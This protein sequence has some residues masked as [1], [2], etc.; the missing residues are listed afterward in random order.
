VRVRRYR[1]S[2]EAAVL[3]LHV[4]A[5]EHAG[6]Y[7]PGPWNDDLRAI[8]EL[9]D[10]FLVGHAD[11]QLVAMGGLRRLSATVGEVKRMRVHPDRQREGLG[12]A[13]LDRLEAS[14]AA[15]GLRELVLDTTTSQTAAQAFYRKNGYEE[16]GRKP[17][18]RFELVFFRK[19]LGGSDTDAGAPPVL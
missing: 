15:L 6:T 5:L 17:H 4:H 10:V 8:D 16:T 14:A 7:L 13:I 9:Y 3:A 2:D 11:G 1:A 18:G 19:R 12:Q